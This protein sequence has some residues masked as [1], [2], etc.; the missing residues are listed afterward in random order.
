M[1][2]TTPL[3]ISSVSEMPFVDAGG[4]DESTPS[5]VTA[6]ACLLQLS[7][8]RKH[9]PIVGSSPKWCSKLTCT[10]CSPRQRWCI[11]FGVVIVVAVAITLAVKFSPLGPISSTCGPFPDCTGDTPYCCDP[12]VGL[13]CS[14]PGCCLSWPNSKCMAPNDVCCDAGSDYGPNIC[15]ANS[16]CCGNIEGSSE[17]CCPPGKT[18]CPSS[19]GMSGSPTCCDDAAGER[20]LSGMSSTCCTSDTTV[21]QGDEGGDCCASGE[22]CCNTFME[23]AGLYAFCCPSP[24]VCCQDGS[25]RCC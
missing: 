21:C 22:V 25:G 13:C 10:N 11:F 8:E 14:T 18:C 1:S 4:D 3:S 16:A 17:Q 15:P 24:S 6:P 7:L 12:L 2:D 23:G 20:C 9:T 5:E 19:E